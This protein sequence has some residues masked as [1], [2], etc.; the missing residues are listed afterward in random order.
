MS[1]DTDIISTADLRL[2]V[3]GL[4]ANIPD[5]PCEVNVEPHTSKCL[6][7]ALFKLHFTCG[8]ATDSC[9]HHRDMVL[10]GPHTFISPRTGLPADSWWC[11]R[12][13]IIVELVR[14]ESLR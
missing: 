4:T 9:A 3:E 12:H 1:V 14:V 6:N 2:W 10:A 11:A 7:Q 13:D 5:H 8:C